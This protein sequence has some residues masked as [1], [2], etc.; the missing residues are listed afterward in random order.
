LRAQGAVSAHSRTPGI[1]ADL[2]TGFEVFVR[3]AVAV[4]AIGE[5]RSTELMNQSWSALT[6][7]AGNQGSFQVGSEPAQRF[8]QLLM[9]AITSGAAHVAD[10]RGDAPHAAGCW[11]WR[12]EKIGEHVRIV[13][14]GKCVG[15]IGENGTDLYLDPVPAYAAA[16]ELG[17]KTGE[18][19]AVGERALGKRLKERG[20]LVR[21]DETRGTL[22]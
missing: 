22:T 14:M 11:G 1:I 7:A 4:G 20:M 3:F 8:V 12:E 2:Q 21:T 18:P 9:S 6:M 5:E 10:F 13:P 15:W 19:L 16:N 17:Q